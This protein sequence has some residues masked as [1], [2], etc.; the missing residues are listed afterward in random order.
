MLIAVTYRVVA[1][2][3]G[4]EQSSPDATGYTLPLAPTGPSAV[5]LGLNAVRISWL[6]TNQHELG[7]SIVED[8]VHVHDLHAT[9]LHLMGLTHTKLTYH[10]QGRDFRLTDVFGK[11]VPK[12]LA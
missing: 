6:D 4:G 12:L 10:F 5:V 7:Y 8:P 3:P 2:A 9:V 1:V 11:V